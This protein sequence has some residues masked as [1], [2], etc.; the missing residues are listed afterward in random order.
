MTNS[1]QPP[2]LAPDPAEEWGHQVNEQPS[3]E[4][5]ERMAQLMASGASDAAIVLG[6]CTECGERIPT[7]ALG[8]VTVCPDCQEAGR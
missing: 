8:L 2:G 7:E 5:R 4:T 3:R 6:L 1:N